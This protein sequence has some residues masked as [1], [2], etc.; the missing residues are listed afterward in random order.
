MES[1]M[2]EKIEDI[3]GTGKEIQVCVANRQIS[4]C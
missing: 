3:E 2:D 1:A 4:T